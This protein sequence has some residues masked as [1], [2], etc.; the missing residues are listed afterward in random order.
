MRLRTSAS[1]AFA[2]IAAMVLSG[3]TPALAE[4][5][6]T[7][8]SS[9]VAPSNPPES[10]TPP[11]TEPTNQPT[12]SATPQPSST[13]EPAPTSS[14]Y[15]DQY[16]AP[17]NIAPL[18][19]SPRDVII[20]VPAAQ[21]SSL[22]AALASFGLKPDFT[23]TKALIGVAV[24][25][26]SVQLS[27]LTSLVPGMIV[28]EQVTYTVGDVQTSAPWNLSMLD[29][30]T[31]PADGSYTYS[32][33]AGAGVKVY[34]IDTGVDA[35][36]QLG[37]RLL[38]GRDFTG[39]GTTDDCNGHG[40]HV[41]GTIAATTYGVAKQAKI[42]PLRALA[43]ATDCT[44]GGSTADVIAAIDWA[45]NDNP[46]GTKAVI[47]MS[48]GGLGSDAAMNSAVTRALNDGIVVVVAAGN[49]GDGSQN[50]PISLSLPRDACSYSPANSPGALTVGAVN[51][52]AT[53]ASFSN[54][55]QCV[56]IFA[57]G[58]NI[59]SLSFSNV[60]GTSTMSGTSMASP[61]VAGAIA[62]YIADN[63]GDTV[64]EI[65][66]GIL[67]AAATNV[68]TFASGH[69]GN[70]NLMLNITSFSNPTLTNST[71]VSVTV[72]AATPAGKPKVG[73]TVNATPGTWTSS[74]TVTRSYE[75][76]T[77]DNEALTSS[78]ALPV[79]CV[80]IPN[81]IGSALA[82]TADYANKHLLTAETARASATVSTVYSATA[83]PVAVPPTVS[84]DPELSGTAAVGERLTLA[85]GI[86]DG[87]PAPTFT[88]RWWACT[89]SV[90]GAANSIDSSKGCVVIANAQSPTFDLRSSQLN[91][92]VIGEVRA[93][94]D[95]VSAPVSRFT[96]S[97]G[98]VTQLPVNT[99]APVV[100]L[101][102][103]PGADAKPRF[104]GSASTSS[105]LSVSN[106]TWTGTTPIT[107]EYIWYSC[108]SAL[109]ASNLL[110]QDCVEIPNE[111][112]ASYVVTAEDVGRTVIAA[113][114]ASN[115]VSITPTVT[116]SASSTIVGSPPVLLFAP[117]ITSVG[118]RVGDAL[119]A[120]DGTWDGATT[121]TRQWYSCAAETG[122][123]DAVQL[124]AP[125]TCVA[126]T[127]ATTPTFTLTTAQIGK[128]ITL[129]VRAVNASGGTV[130]VKKRSA[131]TVAV[132][133]TPVNT[134]APKI[135]LGTPVGAN[136]APRYAGVGGVSTPLTLSTGTWSGTPVPTYA[137]EW[138]RCDSSL[139]LTS[140][141][142]LAT[143]APNGCLEIVSAQGQ[144]RYTVGAD[145]E[146]KFIVG[147]VSA[148]NSA[149]TVT[150][151]TASTAAVTRAPFVTSDPQLDAIEALVGNALTVSTGVWGGSPAPTYAY[152][153]YSCPSLVVASGAS[154]PTGCV[155]IVGAT[156]AR[157]V[158]PSTLVGK[159]FVARVAAING[160]IAAASAPVRYSSSTTGSAKLGPLVTISTPGVNGAP[161]FTGSATTSSLLTASTGTWSGTGTTTYG[162]QWYRCLSSVPGA[163]AEPQD[164]T[165]I[166]GATA[167]TYRIA[168]PDA[169]SFIVAAVSAT[170][171][172]PTRTIWSA[173]TGMVTVAPTN[174]APPTITGSAFVGRQVSAVPG[175][176]S[177]TPQP[178]LTYKW[179]SCTSV[180]ATSLTLVPSGCAIIAGAASTTFTI[181]ASQANK[182]IVVSVTAVNG[183]VAA[184]GITK[185][186][187]STAK[188]LTE[189]TNT[190]SPKMVSNS[191]V[192]ASPIAG[193]TLTVTRGTWSGTPTL[194][195]SQQ[196]YSCSSA[197]AA[198][199]ATKP[200]QCDVI[201]GATATTFVVSSDY[202]GSFITV[203]ETAT[204]PASS[205][206]RWLAATG[207]VVAKPTRVSDPVLSGTALSG[208]QLTLTPGEVTGTPATT[209]AIAWFACTSA[210]TASTLVPTGCTQRG[211]ASGL[212][213]T[214]TVADAGMFITARETASNIA[215]TNVR[216]SDS[217]T[218]VKSPPA[219]TA[220]APVTVDSPALTGAPRVG[221]S[222]ST[223]G[224]TW[225]GYPVPDRA[226]QWLR[227][228]SA[229]AQSVSVA[230]ADCVAV[231][232]ATE[233]SY[234]PTVDDID[235]FLTAQ[236]TAS[237]DQG[238][239]VVVASSTQ[240]EVVESPTAL[241]DP[242]LDASRVVGQ[243]LTLSLGTWRGTP[244]PTT[245]MSWYRCT[246]AV[247]VATSTLP[248]GCV[249]INDA[250]A[251]AS[252]RVLT[253]SDLGKFIIGAVKAS[254]AAGVTTRFTA[255]SQSVASLP[256]P[257]SAPVIAGKPW[258]GKTLT[259][260]TATFSGTPTPTKS[261]AWYACDAPQAVSSITLPEGC[262]AIAGA[263][264]ATLVVPE[265]LDTQYLMFEVTA[266]NVAGS[267][268]TRSATTTN[269]RHI[270][271]N[272]VANTVSGVAIA[273][274]GS[275]TTTVGEWTGT[276][277]LTYKTEWFVCVSSQPASSA[278]LPVGCTLIAGAVTE[279]FAPKTA[280]V[281]KYVLSR[282]TASN[283]TEPAVRYS[284]SSSV[285]ASDPVYVS[286][287]SVT[288]P[289]PATGGAPR[290]GYEVVANPGLWNGTPTPT[291]TYQWYLCS[292][293]RTVVATQIPDGCDVVTNATAARLM[294][295][296]DMAGLFPLA[297]ITGS[298]VAGTLSVYSPTSAKAVTVPP[299]ETTLPAVTGMPY[300]S[301]T[302]TAN[303]GVWTGLPVPTKT[304]AWYSCGTPITVATQTIPADCVK[305]ASQ[306][307][308]TLTV[309]L[310]H[311]T[312]HISALVTATNIAGTKAILT[313]SR[314]PI[315][316]GAVN[317]VAPTVSTNGVSRVGGTA[318]LNRGTWTGDPLPLAADDLYQWY[319]CPEAVTAVSDTVAEGCFEI[320]DQTS[321]SYTMTIDD[322]DM[323]IVALVTGHNSNGDSTV[324]TKSTERV[325][326]PPAN[327]AAPVISGRPFART[328]LT[329]TDGDWTGIPAPTFTYQWQA[330]DASA[331]SSQTQPVACSD[332]A[333]AD[334]SSFTP[335][336]DEIGD[337]ILVRVT[338][339]NIAGNVATWSAS[340][341]VIE[342]GPVNKIAPVVT[343]VDGTATGLPLVGGSVT[344]TGGTWLGRPVPTKEYQWMRCDSAVTAASHV[345][346]PASANCEDIAQQTSDIYSLVAADRGKFILVKVT[347]I[348]ASGSVPHW[349]AT[350]AAVTMAPVNSIAPT[351]GGVVFLQ[352]TARAKSDE[353][354]AFPAVTRTYSWLLCDDP[355]LTDSASAPAGCTTVAGA[356]ASTFTVP[357]TQVNKY[358]VV[359]VTATNSVGTAT[360]YSATS[361]QIVP[362]AVNVSEPLIGGKA[363]VGKP[364]LT[365]SDGVWTPAAPDV[366]YQW[367]RCASVSLSAVDELDPA[368]S[369]SAIPNATTSVYEIV[370]DD[371][372]RALVVGV[373]GAN[374]DGSST[375]FTKSTVLVTELPSI[376]TEPTITGVP[377]FEGDLTANLGVWRGFPN[378]TNSAS[379]WYVCTARVAAPSATKPAACSAIA[380]AVALTF[381]P[382]LAQVGKYLVYGVT[383][384]NTIDGVKNSLTRFT[385][386]TDVV[387]QPAAL[388][389][390]PF[391]KVYAGSSRTARASDKNP[392]VGD[393]LEI[394]ALWKDPQ[395]AKSFQW[396]R[397][398]SRVLQAAR[399]TTIPAGCAVID[400]ATSS[401][402][403]VTV[404]DKSKFVAA[405][406]I[407]TNS[408]G[409]VQEYSNS[410]ID[411]QQAPTVIVMPSISG[412]RLKGEDLT[413]DS[414]QWDGTP[415]PTIGYQ[416]Y[417]CSSAVPAV[418]E[419]VPTTCTMKGD[420]TSAVYTQKLTGSDDGKYI[421]ARVVATNG[422]GTKSFLLPVTE[423]EATASLPVNLE[424]PQIDL[425][426]STFD[427]EVGA[428]LTEYSTTWKSA[429]AADISHQWFRCTAD[430]VL[431]SST[432]DSS[433]SAIPDLPVSGQTTGTSTSQTY[434]VVRADL[435]AFLVV[436]V[437]ASNLAGSVTKFSRSTAQIKQNYLNTLE[438]DIAVP[439]GDTTI[440]PAHPT[441]TISGTAGEWLDKV[442]QPITGDG[443]TGRG[444]SHYWVF[445]DVPVDRV[446]AYLPEQ[447]G[448]IQEATS[449]TLTATRTSSFAGQYV[450]YAEAVTDA[451]QLVQ[452]RLS[453]TTS[454]IMEAP[455]LWSEIATFVAPSVTAEPTV[456]A[457]ASVSA[458]N[459]RPTAPLPSAVTT[460]RGTEIGTFSYQWFSCPTL[461]AA[462]TTSGLPAG[463][464]EITGATSTSFTPS[465]DYSGT[466]L[467]AHITATNSLG[468]FDVW[469]ATSKNVTEQPSNITPPT[470]S[471]D[472]I[473]GAR[474]TMTDGTWRGSPVPSLSRSWYACSNSI[475]SPVSVLPSNCTQIALAFGGS[476]TLSSEQG[477]RYVIAAVTAANQLR[478]G[479]PT[480]SV[481]KYSASTALI[482]ERPVSITAPV[483]SGVANVGSSLTMT[484]GSWRGTPTPTLS[485]RW[486]EC[487]TAPATAN[488]S[489]ENVAADC[490]VLAGK[491]A[492]TLP[493]TLAHTGKYIVGQVKAV[494]SATTDSG[495]D[496]PRYRATVAS[497]P[498]REG[499]SNQTEPTLS[500]E[501]TAGE[502]ITAAPGSWS[503]SATITFAYSWYA[504]S[505]AVYAA[506][507]TA[508]TAAAPAGA[509]CV[510]I[511]GANAQTFK[512]TSA[513]AG[514]HVIAQ[515]K[516][517]NT[518]NGSPAV[519]SSATKTSTS[520]GPIRLAPT[521][522]V[523]PTVSGTM[524]VGE[525][526]TTAAGT[527]LGSPTPTLSY[528]W[529]RCPSSVIIA[530]GTSV[531]PVSCVAIPNATSASISIPADA[532]GSRLVSMVT[533]TN[534][535]SPSGVAKSS[536]NT[537]VVTSRPA[538]TVAP[539]LSGASTLANS[540]NKV[541]VS[542]GTWTG[543]PAPYSY[544]Y[545]WYTCTSSTVPSDTLTSGCSV[546]AAQTASSLVLRPAYAGLHIVARV[547]AKSTVNKTGAGESSTFSAS[548]GQVTSVPTNSVLPTISG[549]AKD[550][551]TLTAN[552]GTWAGVETPTLTHIWYRCT[553]ATV[554]SVSVSVAPATCSP[555]VSADNS[556]LALSTAE[557]G[558]KI[559]LIVTAR[560]SAGSLAKS[561]LLTGVV[562]AVS[563]TSVSASTLGT[564][565][566]LFP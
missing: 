533:A 380:G 416:W 39:S 521:M 45:I 226:Y 543:S 362:G 214:L 265:L 283:S 79:D 166:S 187:V 360:R 31:Y 410:T 225:T 220:L 540:V 260:T 452:V 530:S 353:W 222:V 520:N 495:V 501:D 499:V 522:S 132:T 19:V 208:Q 8:E 73:S 374:S 269:I 429:P 128:F 231:G 385:A 443:A 526:A 84:T 285:I 524:H 339:H 199:V 367:Y 461:I 175:T 513:Q 549:T 178:T 210:T 468:S 261:F 286:G 293:V 135:T 349:S 389:A 537:I 345:A 432:L 195:Y 117:S 390:K 144:T 535:V 159:F 57:P 479:G 91:K 259:A 202:T 350:S 5:L 347:G 489:L 302:L 354:Q 12:P 281:G 15:P 548:F 298:N 54:Y 392:L 331:T 469:T 29:Q 145:D 435:G 290:A 509:G 111:R 307:K 356:E 490:T 279:Q 348:N 313:V 14:A 476:L 62:L 47:N 310:A 428:T 343:V 512:L 203:A 383:R 321:N 514:K 319:R 515:V 95:A 256:A 48:I 320:F 386:S 338:A 477:G 565:A 40:T 143:V 264:S 357:S 257:T 437:T 396:L 129:E 25:A 465:I 480:V 418:T 425:V 66:Q 223:T 518:L 297:R 157:Y 475:P 451:G 234:V 323:F 141:V 534:S 449:D 436:G 280:H 455:S 103:N 287:M 217:T 384:Y 333:G 433:C 162:Y 118:V 206:T 294:I 156:T 275:L 417:T 398:D 70:P 299:A 242:L 80:V 75:W 20:Q 403:V 165:P 139:A 546:I 11:V 180:V 78:S 358:L 240:S 49:N 440:T 497:L 288:V 379:N 71:P 90:T 414:G 324:V 276:P 9:T 427:Y 200:D 391:V 278:T 65:K 381:S 541:S 516:A 554:V 539:T 105:R 560:N 173:A 106:G 244:T 309:A 401:T 169:G 38:A 351:V 454:R 201:D 334:E 4:D 252:T 248:A 110:N 510:L 397:C 122:A 63:P 142:R 23:Y 56:D 430:V 181:T 119:T 271:V 361:T 213:Y 412:V 216:F 438:L 311:K 18:S 130:A 196:W 3:F 277:T 250:S 300:V 544:T 426:D 315:T 243:T 258:V 456:G 127:G 552:R 74:A 64:D 153:W 179:Y 233:A 245:A 134:V 251:S 182:F 329:T 491:T 336:D 116:Y 363:Q 151:F 100:T 53:E 561:S 556:V 32:A 184:T 460:W 247:P 24:T 224:G 308:P 26:N 444:L 303:P 399:I 421:T 207:S 121:L 327:T 507:T 35:N 328:L 450:A 67:D 37:S 400:G 255:N 470:V 16:L 408:A 30:S 473:V 171:S 316:T 566:R 335:G 527:W 511:T 487:D 136:L 478:T 167:K 158:I 17:W 457:A 137:F 194:S 366:I 464:S 263:T 458:G 494:N 192:G 532:A 140:A 170:N 538:N 27:Q 28:S 492:S 270:P 249:Q 340:T 536:A 563:P 555:I 176:W 51:S 6:A 325:N 239:V 284:A 551:F 485:Y 148:T 484:A 131:S 46:A 228:T 519:I 442:N 376:T 43:P 204:N 559:L 500:A 238:V 422:S 388:T 237:N 346:P 81:Q 372:G 498:V 304:F 402:Y 50:P 301:A 172:L 318:T 185:Y 502:I 34:V 58:V 322:A 61:H 503:G 94:S 289:S 407:G 21:L 149:G 146:G 493:L 517:S 174:T 453:K 420:E 467:G 282:V 446:M 205:V 441:V 365:V 419:T 109:P 168:E 235:Y 52:S 221:A 72:A 377:E 102:A 434:Q 525:T 439:D 124:T 163:S 332:I 344:T 191:S 120:D 273:E 254:S 558:K 87:T 227:C 123:G 382:S 557:V 528:E 395:P 266:T 472:N 471:G 296:P 413:V 55:G 93:L 378:L 215:G 373:T 431:S 98:P 295:T 133:A 150:K 359:R 114:L 10:S 531:L 69:T 99:V 198:A 236:I 564:L 161:R 488:S 154:V 68:V 545:A 447:C 88:Y 292:A 193:A 411:I 108:A 486:F 1:V 459:W 125:A 262:Q 375:K 77:C 504:C 505:S 42:V 341:A 2:A 415:T 364:A 553:A 482:S 547:T 394:S 274:R 147:A 188:V 209:N 59:T 33:T 371:A 152:Q 267:V 474:L 219:N 508:P 177:G 312:K 506:V 82:V 113:V 542:N 241:E 246:V 76:Y 562:A 463:C 317:V 197:V 406:A 352:G 529:F 85:D 342:S 253:A 104:T 97:V 230:P 164:C 404:D 101:S 466:Y 409:T 112:S 550:G 448:D 330:C 462:Y 60:N 36:S 445:C 393:T 355:V 218:V 183:A 44:G 155:A 291:Y 368:Q 7:V 190:V 305:I 212:T 337:Y 326:V 211:S 523:A 186:S 423:A 92:H 83:G 306:I 424:A 272:T 115:P 41:A 405:S 229:V 86:W 107:F 370:P 481:T 387:S 13:A 22:Q 314:G 126:I 369:C 232:G 268:S 496:G 96:S 160:A 483:L 89:S 138:Y 189:P